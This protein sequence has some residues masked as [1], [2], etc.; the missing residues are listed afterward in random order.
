MNESGVANQLL[1]QQGR[2]EK[3]GC[4]GGKLFEKQG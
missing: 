3:F 1:A 4:F 2:I